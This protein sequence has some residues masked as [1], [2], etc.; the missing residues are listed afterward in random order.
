MTQYYFISYAAGGGFGSCLIDTQCRPSLNEIGELIGENLKKEHDVTCNA[1]IL[2][3]QSLS[4]E[5]YKQLKGEK[6]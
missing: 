1:I 3:I 6:E 2:N 5:E 4:E